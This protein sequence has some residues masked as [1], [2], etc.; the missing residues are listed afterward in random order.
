MSK[1][2]AFAFVLVL[3]FGCKPYPETIELPTS[4]CLRVQHH[5]LPIP[6][7][8][9]YII[10]NTDTFPGYD[11]PESYFDEKM[12]ADDQAQLCFK[13]V[14]EGNHWVVGYGYDGAYDL[15]GSMRI[16]IDLK[17]R[18]VIDTIFYMSE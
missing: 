1:I 17:N 9:L 3:V 10:Y 13:S 2:A 15:L 18:P 12:V 5:T 16:H 14:P 6:D 4:V 7:A 11:K 8:Q